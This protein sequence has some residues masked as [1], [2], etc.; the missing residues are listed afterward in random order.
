M[1]VRDGVVEIMFIEPEVPGDPFEVSD[2]DTMLEY[3]KPDAE[4]PFDISVFSR[5]GCPYCAKAKS[6]LEEAGLGF[7]ELVLNR[8]YTD[9]TLRAV[10]G[11]DTVPQ[12]FVNGKH[13][14]GSEA[15]ESWLE[16]PGTQA[17]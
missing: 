10:P 7:E 3:L 4:K 5:P 1:L 15:L 12:I 9:R 2:A 13:I 16:Q 6:L 17:A 8:N 11:A 14:G